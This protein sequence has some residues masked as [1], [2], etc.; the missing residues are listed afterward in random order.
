MNLTHVTKSNAT[1]NPLGLPFV[2]WSHRQIV[3]LRMRACQAFQRP[4]IRFP[5]RRKFTPF[6][7]NS[8][9]LLLFSLRRQPFCLPS[10]GYNDA[11]RRS[12]HL[13]SPLLF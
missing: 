3:A 10:L 13:Q 11:G 4:W 6:F 5:S 12:F 7:F 9:A 1:T 2:S 8:I